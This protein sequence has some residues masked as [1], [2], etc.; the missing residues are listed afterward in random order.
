MFLISLFLYT[1]DDD[2]L[3]IH[4]SSP[5]VVQG[6]NSRWVEVNDVQTISSEKEL[7]FPSNKKYTKWTHDLMKA[8]YDQQQKSCKS[9]R[10]YLTFKMMFETHS[11]SDKKTQFSSFHNMRILRHT[12]TLIH[13]WTMSLFLFLYLECQ[14]RILW[15]RWSWSTLSK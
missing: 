9:L 2:P 8:S 6:V 13:F 5:S 15:W 10:D 1:N 12:L 3:A 11:P 4:L 14:P 7:R